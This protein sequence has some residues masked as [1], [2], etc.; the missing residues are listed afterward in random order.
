M[1]TILLLKE[2]HPYNNYTEQIM[3]IELEEINETMNSSQ[4]KRKQN[5]RN[6]LTLG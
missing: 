3:P 6:I 2:I 5:F 4:C 1:N